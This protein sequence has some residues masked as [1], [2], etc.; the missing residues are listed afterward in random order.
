MIINS[1]AVSMAAKTSKSVSY[2]KKEATFLTNL[3]TGEKN[4]SER[5]FSASY[6][7]SFEGYNDFR[8]KM[9]TYNKNGRLPG[10][11]VMSQIGTYKIPMVQE[12]P[13]QQLAAQLRGFLF[14]FRKRLSLF[15]GRGMF[16]GILGNDNGMLNLS[17]G[18]NTNVWRRVN[19]ASYTYEESESLNFETTGKVKTADGREIDF[20]MSLEM[21]R[22]YVEE[23]ENLTNDVVAIMTDPLVISLDSSP[24]GVS[25]QKWKFDIDGDGIED[26]ISMLS[27]GSAFLAY[28]KNGDGKINDGTELFG[29]ATGNGFAELSQYDDDGNGWIDENDAIYSK[30]SVW[31]KD[32]AGHDRLMSLKEANVGAIFLDNMVTEYSMKS[33]ED[34]AHNAQIRKSGMYL[35]EDGK[36]RSIQQLDMA[37]SMVS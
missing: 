8:E 19:Y 5:Q 35:T 29:A 20:N 26:G 16:G 32:D 37:K 11:D 36:A 31:Q 33:E 27:K 9:P 6:E 4:Y 30:L 14:S 25:D 13:V 23:T 34:N 21:S 24:I 7:Q 3:Q 12:D 10:D 28:D 15:L 18:G 2:T 17:S 1:S 22:E